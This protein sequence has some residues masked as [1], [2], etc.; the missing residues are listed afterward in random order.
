MLESCRGRRG[1]QSG[2]SGCRRATRG[3]NS[4]CIWGRLGGR[5]LALRLHCHHNRLPLT[6]LLAARPL[7]TA[8]PPAHARLQCPWR[9]ASRM[10]NGEL[11]AADRIRVLPPM[12]HAPGAGRPAAC[13]HSAAANGRRRR[14]KR[15]GW[16]GEGMG[17]TEGD[18]QRVR[19][20]SKSKG[21][22]TK[23]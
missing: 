6:L 18:Q 12:L 19:M 11:C 21:R 23:N 3:R 14:Q 7:S 15:R 13:P 8:L 20:E 5:P 16:D 22:E 2:C 17:E 9:R 1:V 4:G 10:P